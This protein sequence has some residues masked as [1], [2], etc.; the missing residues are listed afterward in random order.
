[1]AKEINQESFD[2]IW[3][4]VIMGSI[5]VIFFIAFFGVDFSSIACL[6]SLGLGVFFIIIFIA[7]WYG[8]KPKAKCPTCGYTN[9]TLKIG[10]PCPICSK[11]KEDE[12]KKSIKDDL[13][14]FE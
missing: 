13:L 1:M 3:L 9:K 12:D 11:K 5:G 10:D 2:I 7:I 6:Y 8:M 14:D 4:I